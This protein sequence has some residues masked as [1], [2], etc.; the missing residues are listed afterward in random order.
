[1]TAFPRPALVTRIPELTIEILSDERVH[2]RITK[3][4]IYAESAVRE[5][6]IVE[7]GGPIE[8]WHGPGLAELN[9]VAQTLVTPLLAEF[10][11]DL[12]ALLSESRP[13]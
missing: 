6:W 9:E 5:Y 2:D 3:R 12:P 8:Q 1:M 7:P 13:G 10:S 4:F 11:V